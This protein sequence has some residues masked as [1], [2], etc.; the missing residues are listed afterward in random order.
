MIDMSVNRVFLR[1][2]RQFWLGMAFIVF[3]PTVFHVLFS[4]FGFNP[5]D[6]GFVLAGSRRILDGQVPHRDFISIRPAGSFFL[7]MLFVLLGGDYVLWVSRYFVWFQFTCIA[8]VWTVVVSDSLETF[9]STM[10]KIALALITFCFSVHSL[11][12][13][14]WHSFDA[15]FFASIGIM[16]CHNRSRSNKKMIGFFLIG[17]SPL[18]RQNF[19]LLIPASI[20]IFNVWRQKRYWFV[21]G[22]PIA[23]YIGYLAIN[24]AVADAILQI[25][26]DHSLIDLFRIGVKPYVSNYGRAAWTLPGSY[27]MN[28]GVVPWAVIVGY[29]ASYMAQGKFNRWPMIIGI[30]MLFGILFCTAR[31]LVIGGYINLGLP[32]FAIFFAIGGGLIYFIYKELNLWPKMIGILMLFGIPFFVARS[33]AWRTFC[34]KNLPSFAVFGAVVGA[35]VYFIYKEQKVTPRI[36]SGALLLILA[37]SV[38]ISLGYNTPAM[39]LGPLILFLIGCGRSSCDLLAQ[40]ENKK[41]FHKS[42]MLHFLQYFSQKHVRTYIPIIIVSL[43]IT[44][45][46]AFNVARKNSIYRDLSVSHLNY[47]LG[48]VLP[49]ANL[50]R[51]NYNTYIFLKDLKVA[52]NIAKEK[53]K[54]YSIIPDLA[55][56]WI[57][58]S[59]PNPLSIDWP[60]SWGEL[61]RRPDLVNRVIRDLEAYR[62]RLI[63]IIQKYIANSLAWGFKPISDSDQKIVQYVHSNFNKIEETQFFELYEYL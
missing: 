7:H 47:D 35:L 51:T 54:E 6:D 28:Y 42:K 16:L 58:S 10:E 55:A 34:A 61:L 29:L 52:K 49:G 56:N 18:F 12:I 11:P 5:T 13:M 8:W 14:A 17:M 62:G 45:L 36:Q 27:V 38:S 21:A 9:D 33:L 37:W 20:L 24:G 63:I 50:I 26:S 32:S 15:L 41:N 31:S 1:G 60:S 44:T 40:E 23:F 48:E 2:D 53:G 4:Q 43:L 25:T 3:V 39:A 19:T 46:I 57:K 30:L 22:L 59:Q